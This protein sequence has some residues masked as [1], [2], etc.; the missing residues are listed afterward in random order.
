LL[1]FFFLLF[2]SQDLSREVD[3]ITETGDSD[4]FSPS[5]SPPSESEAIREKEFPGVGLNPP[6]PPEAS[7]VEEAPPPEA[8]FRDEPESTTVTSP[9]LV[10]AGSAQDIEKVCVRVFLSLSNDSQHS[11]SR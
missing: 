7:F 4:P 1:I 10:Q 9:Y 8:S 3:S 6:P 11:S 2:P 5:F